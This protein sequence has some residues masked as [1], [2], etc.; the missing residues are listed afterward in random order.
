MLTFIYDTLFPPQ[1]G[2]T[3]SATQ[4]VDNFNLEFLTFA[5]L[6]EVTNDFE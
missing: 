1:F 3:Q 2:A 5:I 4:F 6:C